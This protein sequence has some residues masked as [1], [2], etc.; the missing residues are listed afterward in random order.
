MTSKDPTQ[1][2]GPQRRLPFSFVSLQQCVPNFNSS[3]LMAAILASDLQLLVRESSTEKVKTV[4]E[5]PFLHTH[6]VAHSPHQLRH[7]TLRQSGS[8]TGVYHE[9]RCISHDQFIL[10]VFFGNP[11][12]SQSLF[13]TSLSCERTQTRFSHW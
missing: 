8:F 3:T 13:I 6:S 1:L 7:Q 2:L 9:I 10:C 5:H 12:A 11:R 4:P